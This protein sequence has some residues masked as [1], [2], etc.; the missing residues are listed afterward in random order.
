VSI[1]CVDGERRSTI[2]RADGSTL[3]VTVPAMGMEECTD[4]VDWPQRWVG[5]DRERHSAA[6][7]AVL[8]RLVLIDLPEG[9][10]AEIC[11]AE[12]DAW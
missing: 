12:Q 4:G 9:A 7:L 1:E 5:G 8:S 6:G 11:G 10:F 3:E 2:L